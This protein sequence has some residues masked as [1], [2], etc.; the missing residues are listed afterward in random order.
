[1]RA[2][3]CAHVVNLVDFIVQTY[4]SSC[5]AESFR[6]QIAETVSCE[7]QG[8]D[9]L[10]SSVDESGEQGYVE[11]K[12]HYHED[13]Q[14]V[15]LHEKSRFVKEKKEGIEV[16]TYIDG[17]YPGTFKAGRNDPC[18]CSSGKKFKKCCG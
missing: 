2:R 6:Q 5:R 3:Y 9:V 13:N 15:M 1:M 16:W 4:H 7:W 14:N 18:P 10:T 11:F 17:V 12:A 8:L